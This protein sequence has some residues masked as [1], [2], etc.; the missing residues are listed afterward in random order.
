MAAAVRFAD[1]Q[2]SHIDYS[3]QCYAGVSASSARAPTATR[4]MQ[5]EHRETH[6]LVSRRTAAG[7]VIA[8]SDACVGV[9]G[10]H[11]GHIYTYPPSRSPIAE[12]QTPPIVAGA[13]C[14][15]D[16]AAGLGVVAFVGSEP[17]CADRAAHGTG[18][19]AWARGGK[20]SVV[21]D[22]EHFSAGIDVCIV[23]LH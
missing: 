5:A 16:G 1:I 8:F 13:C 10:Y 17:W 3:L 6:R 19:K 22:G 12:A 7:V 21:D 14:A 9:N 23:R 15:A 18:A 2:G 20:P 4:A 11:V